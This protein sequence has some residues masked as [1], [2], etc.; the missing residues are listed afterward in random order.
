MASTAAKQRV[1]FLHLALYSIAL[2]PFRGFRLEERLR[3]PMPYGLGFLED[4]RQRVNAD[5]C[6]VYLLY[7][8]RESVSFA[9][10]RLCDNKIYVLATSARR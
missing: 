9:L 3:P 7:F 1:L 8:G 4:V 10:V 2:E 6:I 5:I